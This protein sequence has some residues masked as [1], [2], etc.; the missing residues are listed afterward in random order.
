LW[1]SI[2]ERTRDSFSEAERAIYG[3]LQTSHQQE[4]FFIIRSFAALAGGSDFPIAQLSLADRISATQPGVKWIIDKFI[5]LQAIKK[6]ADAR[7]NN[8]SALYRWI[9]S[10]ATC[11]LGPRV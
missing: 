1:G 6:T 4:T 8:R 3:Q 9:A 7:P 11:C 5:A 2:L 10:Q